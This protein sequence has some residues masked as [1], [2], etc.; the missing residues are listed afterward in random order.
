MADCERTRAQTRAQ[1]GT[2]VVHD[3]EEPAEALD[4]DF[5]IPTLNSEEGVEPGVEPNLHETGEDGGESG[6]K[7]RRLNFKNTEDRAMLLGEVDANEFFGPLT[8][9]SK[10]KVAMKM[11]DN[12]MKYRSPSFPN[13]AICSQ[14]TF[15]VRIEKE[16]MSYQERLAGKGEESGDH[17]NSGGNAEIDRLGESIN[18][19]ES[20]RDRYEALSAN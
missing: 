13:G 3:V 18:K 7:P 14:R 6:G 9:G 10:G 5:G 15:D 17:L 11:Q 8:H 1:T 12:L 2:N 16:L 20:D 4:H 19:H